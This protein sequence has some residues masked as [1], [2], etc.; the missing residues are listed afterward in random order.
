MLTVYINYR[1]TNYNENSK[2]HYNCSV[3]TVR[4]VYEYNMDEYNIE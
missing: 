3:C 4:S 1:N 2:I